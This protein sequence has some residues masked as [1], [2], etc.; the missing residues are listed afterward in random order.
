M[1]RKD[2]YE[3]R[4]MYQSPAMLFII[5]PIIGILLIVGIDFGFKWYHNAKLEDATKSVLTSMME[6]DYLDTFQKK[7]EFCINEFKELGYTEKDPMILQEVKDYYVL[8]KYTN[9]FS[10]INTILMQPSKMTVAIYKGSYNEY[11]EPVIEKLDSEDEDQ[12]LKDLD[13][14]NEDNEFNEVN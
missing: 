1:A 11:T 7:K 5:L 10:L 14:L 4:K 12:I 2:L 3:S 9:Y 8:T 6:K 13:I